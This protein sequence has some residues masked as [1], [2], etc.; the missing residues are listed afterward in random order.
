MWVIVKKDWS[1]YLAEIEWNESIYAYWDTEIIAKKELVW[2]LSMMIDYHSEL[3]ESEKE[4]Q[5]SILASN[6]LD[7]A[8]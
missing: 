4:L 7:Y 3:V 6:D 1:W 8:V 5:K 2:V